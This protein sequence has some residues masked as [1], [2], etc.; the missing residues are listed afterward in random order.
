MLL[1][2]Q[3]LAGFSKCEF[4]HWLQDIFV[5]RLPVCKYNIHVLQTHA[6]NNLIS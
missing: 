1:F 2:L 5:D 4:M 6:K 3:D